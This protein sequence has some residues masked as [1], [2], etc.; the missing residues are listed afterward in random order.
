MVISVTFC[1]SQSENFFYDFVHM[2]I[3]H[4]TTIIIVRSAAEIGLD[5]IFKK[6]QVRIENCT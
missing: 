4:Y 2:M 1:N 5:E 3:H 6:I